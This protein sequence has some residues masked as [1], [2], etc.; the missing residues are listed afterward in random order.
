MKINLQFLYTLAIPLLILGCSDKDESHMPAAEDGQTTNRVQESK[1]A[2]RQDK[3]VTVDGKT[4]RYQ[5]VENDVD[6]RLTLLGLKKR[7]MSKMRISQLRVKFFQ[8]AIPHYVQTQVYVK[9]ARGNG[10]AV[11]VGRRE[12]E[13]RKIAKAYD[14]IS[15]DAL[16]AHLTP[17][18]FALLEKDLSND[19]LVSAAKE[20]ILKDAAISITDKDVKAM[21]DRLRHL[22]QVATATNALV[23]AHATNIWRKIEAN[24]ITFSEAVS[25]YSESDD[26][27]ADG[28]WAMAKLS[29]MTDEPKLAELLRDLHAGDV[30]PPI[31]VDNGLCIIKVNSR[32]RDQP[33]DIEDTY[34]LCRIYLRLPVMWEPVPVA[35]LCEEMRKDAENKALQKKFKELLAQ[36]KVEQHVQK[37]RPSIPPIL[38]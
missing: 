4:L 38:K 25:D 32:K 22:N 37:P 16:R 35:E 20:A 12:Q 11:A 17:D 8:Q 3:L 34:E 31:E 27:S 28:A 21:Q 29:Q 36:S 2:P 5:D 1:A 33:N 19:L 13:E 6:L 18:Q 23:Y 9:Y 24:H 7:K 26:A 15:F 10:I 30:T 14:Q